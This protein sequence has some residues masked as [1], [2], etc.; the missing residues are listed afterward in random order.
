[1]FDRSGTGAGVSRRRLLKGMA[2]GALATA[3][4]AALPPALAAAAQG[5]PTAQ[6]DYDVIVVGGGF[7]GVTAARQLRRK[8]LA[9]LLLEARD[10][11][12]GRAWTSTFEGEQVEMGATWIDPLQTNVWA[13][14]QNQGISIVA[15]SAPGRALFPTDTGMG[16]FSVEEAFGGQGELLARFSE[17]ARALFPQPYSPLSNPTALAQAD[18]LT[19]RDR[20]NALSLTTR[21]K[22]W[23]DAGVGPISGLSTRGAMTDFLHWWALCNYD[24]ATYHGINTYRPSTGMAGLLNKMLSR[25]APD[26]KL[27]SPVTAVNDS[28]SQVSV[29]TKSGTTYTARACVMAV[30]VNVWRTIS[31]TPALSS[32]RL[33]ASQETIGV[34]T[35]RKFWV[36]LRSSL[37]NTYVNAPESYSVNV[38]VPYK[39]TSQGYL[40]IGFSVDPNL[41]VSNTTAVQNAIRALVPDAQVLA[42]KGANWGSDPYALGGWSFRRPRQLTELLSAI[43]KPQGRIAFAGSD[44]ASGWSGYVDGA[45]ESGVQAALQT[46][47]I[48]GV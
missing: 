37:G 43:Q 32:L 40:M 24:A 29:R 16:Y 39:Q 38:M 17:Q 30:P 28:G 23:L 34:G 22:R 48:L 4:G 26:V 11:V 1:M 31:F 19:V 7:A 3:A 12:G 41:D 2:A 20:I 44:I 6:A 47:S 25:D 27:N 18:Q 5:G 42:L 45:M 33:R 35:A 9:V 36:H 14:T 46:Q 15:D 8:G 21:E 10:R 13:E